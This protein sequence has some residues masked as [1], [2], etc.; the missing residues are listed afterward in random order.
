METYQYQ[1]IK[2][3]HDHFT[4]EFVNVGVV[5]YDP[6]SPYLKCKVTKGSKRITQYFPDADGEEVI[7]LLEYF[8]R[9]ILSKSKDL[10]GLLKSNISIDGITNAILQKDNSAIQYSDV[11]MGIDFDLDTA[12]NTLYWDLVAKYSDENNN[13]TL[14]TLSLQ[15]LM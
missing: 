2:Y 15:H 5:V 7:Q 12:L 14:E 11:K 10:E 9:S 4:S 13:S 1:I 8:E 6:E 3:V